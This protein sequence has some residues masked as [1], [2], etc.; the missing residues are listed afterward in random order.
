MPIKKI[1][2]KIQTWPNGPWTITYM[3]RWHEKHESFID[4]AI[5]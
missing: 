1:K 5:N 2:I 3:D 4:L